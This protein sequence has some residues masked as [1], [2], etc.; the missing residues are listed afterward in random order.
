MFVY[1]WLGLKRE[2][3]DNLELLQKDHD[4]ALFK[5]RGQQAT[6]VEYYIEKIQGLEEELQTLRPANKKKSS[7]ISIGENNHSVANSTDS[8]NE[9]NKKCDEEIA[10]VVEAGRV[11]SI[12]KREV[13]L[14][15]FTKKFV[16]NFS[17]KN[18]VK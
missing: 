11:H 6:S 10:K 4:E 14:I 17:Q 2:H 7:V 12:V 9:P 13:C 3:K 18:S 5:L 8:S 16:Y 1:I 15:L